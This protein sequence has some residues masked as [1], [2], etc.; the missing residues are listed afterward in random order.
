M[1]PEPRLSLRQRLT[2]SVAL[3]GAVGLYTQPPAPETLSRVFG[4]PDLRPQRA[5]HY[6][7]GGDVEITTTLRVEAAGFWKDMRN[8]VVP[9]AGP[10]DP[11]LAND[12]RGRAYGGEL[13]VR[14]QLWKQ[15]LRL[16]RLHAVAQRAPGSPRRGV[17]PLP[18]RSDQ[19]PDAARQLPACRAGFQVG[20][21]YRY[22]TG[23]PYTPVDGRL[24]RLQRRRYMPI[25]GA[26][27]QRAPARVQPARPAGGQA[28]GPSIAGGFSVYL[29]VQNATRATNAEA[30]S[31]NFDFTSSRPLAGL[32]LLPI[33]G[34]R[35]DF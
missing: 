29:D 12:G 24:L 7:L 27:V 1:A 14:Q 34:V 6:V 19:H 8:L 10:D 23:N 33:C 17:A 9:G 32:P 25:I 20:A 30:V 35:G 18:L 2:Q 22:V 15:L 3:K 5:T 16:D 21:R 11:M 31:F 28:S 26:A 4:N 13:L